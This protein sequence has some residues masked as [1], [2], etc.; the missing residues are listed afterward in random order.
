MYKIKHHVYIL[1]TTIRYYFQINPSIP[2]L[3]I[4]YGPLICH[5][6]I[7]GVGAKYVREYI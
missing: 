4:M 2:G 1:G 5:T 3:G 6:H 7:A